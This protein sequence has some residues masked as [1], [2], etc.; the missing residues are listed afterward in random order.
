MSPIPAPGNIIIELVGGPH[1]GRQVEV[2]MWALF[3]RIDRD[4]I[5]RISLDTTDESRDWELYV[6]CGRRS[7]A[8]RVVFERTSRD[9][10]PKASSA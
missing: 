10:R 7:Q 1:C 5:G 9:Y 2:P 6:A 4:D 8:G 3:V